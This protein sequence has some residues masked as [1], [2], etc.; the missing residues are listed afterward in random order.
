M[1]KTPELPD[2]LERLNNW[3]C[4]H[5]DW[6]PPDI[7]TDRKGINLV[8]GE[9][10]YDAWIFFIGVQLGILIGFCLALILEVL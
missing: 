9:K 10:H 7:D 1:K 2:P 8:R 3:R 5:P 6:K 4:M